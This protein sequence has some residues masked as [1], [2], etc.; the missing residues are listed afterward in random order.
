MSIDGLKWE[1]ENKNSP[2]ARKIAISISHKNVTFIVSLFELD[3]IKD[4]VLYNAKLI[5]KYA[6][7][8]LK[9]NMCLN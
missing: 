9:K 3:E 5:N 2:F 4:L 7:D 8:L 6:V 1:N